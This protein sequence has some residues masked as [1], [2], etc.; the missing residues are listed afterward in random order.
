MT[1]YEVAEAAEKVDGYIIGVRMPPPP[2][3][4]QFED[5]RQECLKHLR[6]RV[7]HVEQLTL[8]QY[9]AVMRRPIEPSVYAELSPPAPPEV[10]QEIAQM[11]FAL[12]QGTVQ[13]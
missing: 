1:Q 4:Q 11:G 10:L 6:A 2:F 7:A 8:D 5:A 9:R 12:S 13:S 3:A